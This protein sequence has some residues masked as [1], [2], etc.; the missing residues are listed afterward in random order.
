MRGLPPRID[1]ANDVPRQHYGKSQSVREGAPTN[2]TRIANHSG[3]FS[4][5]LHALTTSSTAS[6]HAQ[7]TTLQR[8]V[9]FL[10]PPSQVERRLILRIHVCYSFGPG[11]FMQG[12]GNFP[13]KLQ[14]WSAETLICIVTSM[15]SLELLH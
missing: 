12:F 4:R 10:S 1:G 14:N 6:L 3:G 13:P 8:V 7:I 9:F 11:K 15:Y 5:S 2:V